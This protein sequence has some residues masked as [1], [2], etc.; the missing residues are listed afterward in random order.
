MPNDFIPA[1]ERYGL[2]GRIDY[3]VLELAFS[4]LAAFEDSPE[5]I[6]LAINLSAAHIGND[7]LARF[8]ETLFETGAVS[9]KNIIFE[10]TETTALQNLGKARAFMD[11][12][13]A[14]GCRFAL[15]DFGVGFTSFAQLR[16]LPVDIVKIDGMFVR[17]LP[18][19]PQDQALVKSITDIAHSLEKQV[20]AEF[21]E[22]AEILG[23][24]DEYGVDYAQGYHIGKPAPELLSA[25]VGSPG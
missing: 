3:R 9:A 16:E 10:I 6:S 25:S 21:V 2:I 8:L 14:L 1:A 4:H 19:K 24:L 18:H 5:K 23:L 11:P 17:E 7:A 13:K 22:N 12:L 20:V 15:D